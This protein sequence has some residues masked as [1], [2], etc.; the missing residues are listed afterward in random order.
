MHTFTIRE[1]RDRT[2]ELVRDAEAGKL[3]VVTKHG[4]PVF[5]AVPFDEVL[6]RGGVNVA[7]A[8]KLFDEDALTIREGAK[9]AGMTLA[10]FMDECA[11]REVSVVRYT[12]EDIRQELADFQAQASDRGEDPSPAGDLP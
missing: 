12:P 8:V 3:S 5:V 10:E 11:A 6:L 9:L 1:L 4:Q 2:G 7:L